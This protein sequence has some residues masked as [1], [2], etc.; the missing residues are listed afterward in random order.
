MKK[1]I[2]IILLV[3]MM[4]TMTGYAQVMTPKTISDL[5]F[6]K[7]NYYKNGNYTFKNIHVGST[8]NGKVMSTAAHSN[9]NTDVYTLTVLEAG[10]VTIEV[11]PMN[12][13]YYTSLVIDGLQFVSDVSGERKYYS[14]GGPKNSIKIEDYNGYGNCLRS[15]YLDPGTYYFS[16]SGTQYSSTEQVTNYLEYVDYKITVNSQSYAKDPNIDTDQSNP[17]TFSGTKDTIKGNVS[18][19]LMY[20]TS[21]NKYNLDSSDRYMIPAGDEREVK[22]TVSN[23]NS[24]P[25]NL[26]KKEIEYKRNND[27]KQNLE[28]R[29]LTSNYKSDSNLSV[30]VQENGSMKLS[31]G[32][33]KEIIAKVKANEEYYLDIRS[34]YPSEYTISYEDMGGSTVNQQPAQTE[35]NS[36]EGIIMLHT[37]CSIPQETLDSHNYKIYINNVDYTNNKGYMGH[38][39]NLPP[40]QVGDKFN[41]RVEVEGYEPY[42]ETITI[43]SVNEG[44]NTVVFVNVNTNPVA[45]QPVIQP[46]EETKY[47]VGD[48]EVVQGEYYDGEVAMAQYGLVIKGGTFTNSRIVNGRRDGNMAVTKEKFNLKNKTIYGE[49]TIYGSNYAWYPGFGVENVIGGGKISTHHSWAGSKVV[50]DGTKL[51]QTTILTETTYDIKIA[52][53]NYF[54]KS[55][56]N[57]I[58]E[59]SGNLSDNGKQALNSPQSIHFYFGD[60]YGNE[61][62][63]MVLHDLNIETAKV[64]EPVTMEEPVVIQDTAL[65]TASNWAREEIQKA[66]NVGLKT[67]KMT[68]SNFKN[69]AT[70]EE[71]A[72]LVMQMYDQLGGQSVSSSNNPF[73]DTTNHE[74]V[75]AFNAGIIN[76]TGSDTFSPNNSLTREQLCVMIL[77]AV[78]KAGGQYEFSTKFQKQYEDI[79][80][81]SSWAKESVEI[82]NGYKIINGNGVNLDPKG[83]VTK[84][85]ALLML[86]RAYEMF[87]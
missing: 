64:E 40:C 18:M 31:S 73:K 39:T 7:A 68:N 26:F 54:G 37:A 43:P 85:M 24:N 75:R 29:R 48:Y 11:T 3:V 6:M 59:D 20:S 19:Q 45:A 65:N 10:V 12:K 80:K 55:G 13:Q 62:N 71:F 44:E 49:Y 63:F 30:S 23:T 34:S 77:R 60:N 53:G 74:I 14:A 2:A 78:N 5:D 83:T 15:V 82:L 61:T 50:G 22:I 17:Y 57:L 33:T 46:E 1:I 67:E 69:Y 21:S 4:F 36:V 8:G 47:F 42:E 9:P 27:D 72:E 52:T 87:K 84:E 35:T 58:Y 76:G 56:S 41:I 32:E 86:Y 81:I 66:I 51:F 28:I 25:L 79:N 70:R 38:I 16:V